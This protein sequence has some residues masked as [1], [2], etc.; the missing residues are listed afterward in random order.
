MTRKITLF[1]EYFQLDRDFHNHNQH[2]WHSGNSA[3][4]LQAKILQIFCVENAYIGTD[5][6]LR[7]LQIHILY[8]LNFIR[9]LVD[10]VYEE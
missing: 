8:L 1:K 9:H 5:E 6:V 3:S 7:G 2:L 4:Y 10:D